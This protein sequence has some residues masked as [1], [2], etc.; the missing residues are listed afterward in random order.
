MKPVSTRAS[1][2]GHNEIRIGYLFILP[3]IIGFLTFVAYPL[4]SSVYYSM[5]E[6]SGFDTPK[7][8][9]LKNY[10]HMFTVDPLFWSSVR[11][12]F[13]YAGLGVPLGLVLGLL[14]ALLLFKPI[15]GVK[16][17]RTLFYLPVVLPAV[18]STT[19]WLFIYQPQYGLL[20]NVLRV[21]GIEGPDWLNDSKTAILSLVILMLWG[22]G[23]NMIIFLSG[24]QSVP[25]DIYE[26]AQIDGATKWGRF[27]H[28]TIP[29][30]TPIL[31]LQF[32]TGLI[33][34]FQAFIQ[35]ALL[36]GS[37]DSVNP[38]IN[39]MNFDIYRRAFGGHDFG[40]AMAEVWVLV[41]I[42]LIV[43]IFAFRLNRYVHYQ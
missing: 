38:N 20:N 30:I 33:N 14:L 10:V 36:N 4:L 12:T 16:I 28:V 23:A 3:G 40:Y 37:K 32:I 31:L 26:S 7:F 5:T 13:L 19:L 29:M 27:W 21:F 43:T 34:A 42:I 39:L 1:R 6:W 25:N 8:V 18:A 9:G 11:L 15:A 22:V 41:V 24:L 2:R 35:P 17:F